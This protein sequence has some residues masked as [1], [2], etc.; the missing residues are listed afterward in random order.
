MIG[1]VKMRQLRAY[2]AVMV[3]G[4]VSTAAEALNLTQPAISKQ[5][6]ALEQALDLQLFIR[7]KGGPM[8]ATRE[9]IAYY[10]AI[11]AVLEGVNSLKDI[12]R[13]VAE[14][15]RPRLRI[16]AT[17]PLL[18][19]RT[20]M[21]ALRRFRAEHPTA[22]LALE[23][24]HRLEIE[25]WVMSGQ[26]DIG[27]ALLPVEHPGLTAIP[28]IETRAVAVVPRS[29]PDPERIGPAELR[30]HTVILPSRQPLRT[31]IDPHLEDAH[32]RIPIDIESSSAL[33][34]CRLV[35]AGLGVSVCDPFSPTAF[36]SPGIRVVP[37]EPE[38][39]LTY[40][41][42]VKKGQQLGATVESLLRHIR[43]R[44]L[45]DPELQEATP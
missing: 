15:S 45:E 9:G 41:V 7:K 20:L 23:P 16:A 5:L 19:S 2:Q 39:T 43:E 1:S 34:C 38:V 4:S 26:V 32:G 17:P 29:H 6:A 14:H 12:A 44:F 27:M 8:T 28:L 30:D 35:A 21:D 31:R 13:E 22:R 11:E 25:D 42:L 3:S 33:T 40:G 18:N 10:K 24:R 37:W 36:P